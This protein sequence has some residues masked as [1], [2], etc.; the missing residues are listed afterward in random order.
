MSDA[1][2]TPLQRVILSKSDLHT[3]TQK[4]LN[5]LKQARKERAKRE[6][7]G[8]KPAYAALGLS[9]AALALGIAALILVFILKKTSTVESCESS[10]SD[11]SSS[12]SSI[13]SSSS[14]NSS[15]SS[16][17]SSNSSSSSS[18]SSSTA[19]SGLNMNG[20]TYLNGNSTST[21]YNFSGNVPYRIQVVARVDSPSSFLAGFYDGGVTASWFMNIDGASKL[22][23]HREHSSTSQDG[24][25]STALS[26][27]GDGSFHT[28]T[29]AYD[30]SNMIGYVDGVAVVTQ[31]DAGSLQANTTP[32]MVG[33]A[34]V[35]GTW[36]NMLVGSINSVQI[37]NSLTASPG[38]MVGSFTFADGQVTFNNE[39]SGAT[40]S[41]T[42]YSSS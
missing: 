9:A 15:S 10:S 30:G 36:V 11:S 26:V 28:F 42:L 31:A 8:S 22:Q 13:S 24:F 2:L 25:S 29:Y 7:K 41:L 17:S 5:N 37:W 12:S 40:D 1:N 14:S 19:T 20:N 34:M 39:V 21:R 4:Q 27:V 6:K 3:A 35:S 16:S 23:L 18:S 38:S 33:G 32:L